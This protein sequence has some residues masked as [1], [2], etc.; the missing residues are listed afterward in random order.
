VKET[1]AW[2]KSHL[3]W[4]ISSLPPQTHAGPLALVPARGHWVQGPT[5]QPG[6]RT[7]RPAVSPCHGPRL[8]EAP[9]TSRQRTYAYLGLLR[10]NQTV[11]L[12]GGWQHPYT[13][14]HPICPYIRLRPCASR[15]E[16]VL[17][18]ANTEGRIQQEKQWP[19][20]KPKIGIK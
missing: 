20:P 9:S 2:A 14:T 17:P 8:S 11:I 13:R 7:G 4:P 5:R 3:S 16:P 6:S 1:C 19:P 12:A 15:R 18:C 10:P